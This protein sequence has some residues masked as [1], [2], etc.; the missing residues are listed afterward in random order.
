MDR[1]PDKDDAPG[2][3]SSV[4]VILGR[5]SLAESQDQVAAAARILAGLPGVAFL[6]ALRRG[7]HP[8]RA[9]LPAWPPAC[10]PAGLGLDDGREWFE[11]HWGA[12]LPA[13]SGA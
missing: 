10:C 8:R 4:V 2:T 1:G 11:Y 12:S 9:R 13:R 6:S 7:Q 3:A 5:P